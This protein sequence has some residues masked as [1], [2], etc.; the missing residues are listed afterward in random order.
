MKKLLSLLLLG[1]V[2]NAN[3]Y[4]DKYGGLYIT[5]P[6][7]SHPAIGV[8][9]MY[10]Y[11]YGEVRAGYDTNNNSQV[12]IGFTGNDSESFV[13]S[14]G[15]AYTNN[16]PMPYMGFTVG[17]STRYGAITY[18]GHQDT[19][20]LFV[21]KENSHDKDNKHTVNADNTSSSIDDNTG[22]DTTNTIDD[23]VVV[24]DDTKSNHSGLSDGTNPGRG[25]EHH[26]NGGV[27][28]PS[29]DE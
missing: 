21:G 8:G 20:Y 25:A 4:D 12:G 15:A 9:A 19:T 11:N 27:G 14:V 24:N 28:N 2:L 3:A 23:P 5:I 6:M 18:G 29:Y 7:S 26:D 22:G 10:R 16:G 1:V 17:H 13:P